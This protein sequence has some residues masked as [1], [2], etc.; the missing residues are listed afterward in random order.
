[1]PSAAKSTTSPASHTEH[2]GTITSLT[3]YE[4]FCATLAGRATMESEEKNVDYGS[5]EAIIL[6]ETEDEMWT[7]DDRGPLG[8]RDLA[9]VV[10]VIEDVQVKWSNSPT[11]SSPF[12][13]PKTEKA[14]YLLI[15]STRHDDSKYTGRRPDLT[16]GEKF[17]WNTSAPR[18]V[19]KI[20]WLEG[21]DRLRQPV[22][23]EATDIGGGQA[24]L[25]LRAAPSGY[26]NQQS[27]TLEEASE[28]PF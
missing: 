24:V 27:P 2:T 16:Q 3:P 26:V 28:S 10:Q 15:T 11:I 23:I 17:Q 12:I 25:K 4:K 18:V 6:A 8:G 19:A 9:G 22:S 20:M 1:M 5:I 7:A 21:H 13:D 14:L